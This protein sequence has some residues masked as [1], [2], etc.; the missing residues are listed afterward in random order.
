MEMNETN[1]D[2]CADTIKM[3][4]NNRMKEVFKVIDDTTMSCR[5]RKVLKHK[6]EKI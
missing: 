2:V 4:L 5:V 3:A 1:C 6:L